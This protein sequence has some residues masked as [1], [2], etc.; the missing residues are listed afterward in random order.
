MQPPLKTLDDFA[1]CRDLDLLP[2]CVKYVASLKNSNYQHITRTEVHHFAKFLRTLTMS[3][4]LKRCGPNPRLVITYIYKNN[5]LRLFAHNSI[6]GNS[7]LFC[8]D[9]DEVAMKATAVAEGAAPRLKTK[10]LG[11]SRQHNT[12]M[13]VC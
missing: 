4:S 9:C 7:L 12:Q 8:R 10:V 3:K 11:S 5:D 13:F 1:S 6:M 2:E